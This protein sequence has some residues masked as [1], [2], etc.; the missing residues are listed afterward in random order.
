MPQSLGH[1]L[2]H[3][4]FSTKDRRPLLDATIRPRMHGYLAA[5]CR[6]LKCEALRVGGVA[7]HVHL[8]IRPWI[9]APNGMNR[10]FSACCA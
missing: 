7:D 3:L 1:I 8:A 5:L 9:V 10:A 2:I 4:I 6:D